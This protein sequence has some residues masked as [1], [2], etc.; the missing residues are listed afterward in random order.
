MI[1][2][3]FIMMCAPDVDP[4]TV[5]DIIRRGEAGGPYAININGGDRV[6]PRDIADALSL[7]K[8]AIAAGK[9]VDIG[10][11]QVNSR[12]GAG[13]GYSVEDLF[14]PCLNLRAGSRVLAD[15]YAKAVLTYGEGQAALRAAL[16]AY[17]TGTSSVDSPT[18]T[19]QN[20]T[21]H[22]SLRRLT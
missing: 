22:H 7:T 11:M 2:L 1:G 4:A 10:Y 16:S 14:D 9:T 15:F 5:Q 18:A 13:L 6:T 20:I 17:N 3:A 12:T 21:T 8:Q 19:L